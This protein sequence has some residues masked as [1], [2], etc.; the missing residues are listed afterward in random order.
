VP[1]ERPDEGKEA[2][3]SSWDFEGGEAIAPGRSVLKRLGGGT[4]YEVYL[5][6][7]DRLCALVVAKILRPDQTEDPRA[8]KELRRE[9]EIVDRLAHPVILRGFDA[10]LDGPRPHIVVEHLEGPTLRR[11]IKR[12]RRLPLEQALPTAVHIAAAVHYLSTERPPTSSWGC[13]LD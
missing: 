1:E 2:G 8:L 3:P 5:S 6:W 9:A 4:R 11:L 12:Q 7:D 13:R 10:V